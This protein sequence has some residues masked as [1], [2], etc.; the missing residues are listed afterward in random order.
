MYFNTIQFVLMCSGSHSSA[1]NLS[2]FISIYSLD[3]HLL[4]TRLCDRCRGI[5]ADRA[6]IQSHGHLKGVL[7]IT[8][9]EMANRRVKP[10]DRPHTPEAIPVQTMYRH[11][12]GG[13]I[14]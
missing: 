1:N 10:P 11:T 6:E 4:E 5:A 8:T 3:R 9:E 13:R 7:C 2:G 12:H 14:Y